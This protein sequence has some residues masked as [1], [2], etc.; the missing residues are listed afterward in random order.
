[1]WHIPQAVSSEPSPSSA[2]REA[3]LTAV[4]RH[5]HQPRSLE[6]HGQ[7]RAGVLRRG[8]R[9]GPGRACGHPP[10]T[11]RPLAG[12]SPTR[13]R[14]AG[15]AS[16]QATATSPDSP[17]APRRLG[18]T[19]AAR[20]GYRGSAP[21]PPASAAPPTQPTAVIR[22]ALCPN[23]VIRVTLRGARGGH[24]GSTGTATTAT[25]PRTQRASAFTARSD[26]PAVPG[27][28]STGAGRRPRNKRERTCRPRS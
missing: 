22:I 25:H 21:R 4:L 6:P 10:P 20:R 12:A 18:T 3:A 8:C 26:R 15:S 9:P 17:P 7:R 14:S 16:Q 19:S 5:G 27:T 1:M 2:L 24:A 13:R 11:S 23:D 28:G